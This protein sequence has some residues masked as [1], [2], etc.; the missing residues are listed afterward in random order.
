MS[1]IKPTY[2][3][4]WKRSFH[5]WMRFV[6]YVSTFLI[7]LIVLT[8]IYLP[9]KASI[10]ASFVKGPSPSSLESSSFTPTDPDLVE[11]GIH[12]AT[13]LAYDENFDLVR[14]VCTSCHSAKL[15]TQNKASREGWKSMIKW[16]QATQGLQDLG[17]AESRIVDYLSKHY[18]PK[19]LGRRQNLALSE[20]EWYKLE[21]D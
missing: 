9:F 20:V 11:N 14:S 7:Y 2:D 6:T 3:E 18:A 15:I 4:L 5:R 8:I 19:E 1:K 13:G 17:K 12:L 10:D 16:M 21:L